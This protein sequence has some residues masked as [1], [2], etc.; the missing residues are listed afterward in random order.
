ME[1][2]QLG[3]CE[4]DKWATGVLYQAGFSLDLFELKKMSNIHSA[5]LGTIL[6]HVSLLIPCCWVQF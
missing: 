5:I 6:A 4:L 1:Y 2:L 3:A